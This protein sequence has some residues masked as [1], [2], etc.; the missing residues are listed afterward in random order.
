MKKKEVITLHNNLKKLNNLTGVKFAY[1]VSRNIGLLEPI[2]KALQDASVP[3]KDYFDYEKER[4]IL[5]EKHSQKDENGN[6]KTIND[7]Y[8]ISDKNKFTDE[9]EK[10]RKKHKKAIDDYFSKME[11]YRKMLEE[12]AEELNIFKIKMADIPNEITVEQMNVIK[13]LIENEE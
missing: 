2:I 7:E 12:E 11:E 9:L 13:D 1:A 5:A 6:P 3:N 10:L 4:V 8:I